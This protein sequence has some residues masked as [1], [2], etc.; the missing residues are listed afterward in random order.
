[1]CGIL[2]LKSIENG[3]AIVQ[4]LR[5]LSRGYDY[6][7]EFI[8]GAF[9]AFQHLPLVQ[10][11][12]FSQQPFV[13][14]EGM[15][16]LFNGEFYNYDK[17]FADSEVRWLYDLYCRNRR[18][19][20]YLSILK[21]EFAYVIVDFSMRRIVFY[22][23]FPGVVPLYYLV[24]RDKWLI[25]S[26]KVLDKQREVEPGKYYIFNMDNG[27]LKVIQKYY[28][29]MLDIR[30]GNVYDFNRIFHEALGQYIMHK[31]SDKKITLSYSGGLDSSFILAHILSR[32][33]Y[34]REIDEIISCQFTGTPEYELVKQN[35]D[36]IKN[37]F[38]ID[39]IIIEMDKLDLHA[40]AK[41]IEERLPSVKGN[42]VK[43]R[44][45]LRNYLVAQKARN[46]IIIGGEGAD[47]LFGGYP[48]FNVKDVFEFKYKQ[49]QALYSMRSINLDRTNIIPYL[50][51][52]EWRV[53]FLDYRVIRY[54][55]S[56]K[57]EYGKKF[58]RNALNYWLNRTELYGFIKVLPSKYGSEEA[59]VQQIFS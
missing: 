18:N 52:K 49:V 25:S 28:E 15:V 42:I 7:E 54:A 47:E 30:V 8:G 23:S 22:R 20:F 33:V 32:Y 6:S 17:N 39:Y 26:E 41:E 10:V 21:G 37:Q 13:S 4:K 9:F 24:G 12:P 43:L 16:I 46:E 56:I 55:L 58:L 48:F 53:P 38:G 29:H 36:F 35:L 40:V 31:D 59:I 1:M 45:A 27:Q 2:T 57:Q 14:S 34:Y 19:L 51:T 3:H 11:G 50:F 5:N 44:G